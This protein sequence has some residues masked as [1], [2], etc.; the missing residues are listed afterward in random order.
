MPTPLQ[1]PPVAVVGQKWS[2]N[3]PAAPDGQEAQV[4]VGRVAEYPQTFCVSWLKNP[5]P[6]ELT[7]NVPAGQ[8]TPQPRLNV[9]D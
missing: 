1:M 3:W 7:T 5:Q 2:Q 6:D 8:G 4:P 9:Q